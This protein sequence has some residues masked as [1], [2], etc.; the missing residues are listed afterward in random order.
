MAVLPILVHLDLGLNEIQNVLLQQLAADPSP[1]EA[2]IYYN[3]VAH[4]VRFYNGSAWISVPGSGGG[5]VSAVTGTAP[6]VSS[7]GTTPAISIVA[8]T[9]SVPGSM[10]A[11]DFA[12]LAAATA[13]ATSSTLALRDSSGRLAVASPSAAG[14]AANKG[15]VDGLMNG[16]DWGESCVLVSTS[17]IASLSG[18]ATSIDGVTATAGMRVLLTAQTTAS[19]NGP[20]VVAS[21]AWTRPV[22]YAA[23][24]T[25]TPNRSYFIEQGTAKHDTG[26]TLSTDTAVT[27]DTTSTAWTQFSGLGEVTAGNGLTKTGDT[28]SVLAADGS[29]TVAVGGIS[30]TAPPL[31][32]SVNVGDGASTAIV[33]THSLGTRDVQ[34]QVYRNSTPWDTVLCDVERTSTTTCT[35]RFNVAPTSN[36]FRAVVLA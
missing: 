28:I 16:A 6:I 27:V 2:R 19:Q 5:T 7:G 8:A 21:G 4:E 33:I 36:Q 23:A 1:L 24:A 26:W 17:N 20:W 11:A 29:I 13:A 30:V 3:T 31:R 22:D 34:V 9:G 14:D 12:K 10:S 32:F 15:Y 35:L 18:V 25:I